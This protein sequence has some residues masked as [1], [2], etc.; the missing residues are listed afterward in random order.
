MREERLSRSALWLLARVARDNEPLAGDLT[1]EFALGRTEWWLRRQL[2]SALLR[3]HFRRPSEIRPLRL[4]DGPIGS[5]FDSARHAGPRVI[6]LS[7]SPV[8]GIGGL[9][10]ALLLGLMTMVSPGV[11]WLALASLSGG[12]LLG[13]VLIARHRHSLRVGSPSRSLFGQEVKETKN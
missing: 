1:E 12:I 7:G 3:T 10:L 13:G 5:R 4:V 11:W 6:N 2:L 9:G 8:H